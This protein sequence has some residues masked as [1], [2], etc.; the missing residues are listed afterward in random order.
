MKTILISFLAILVLGT[1]NAKPIRDVISIKEPALQAEAYVNDIPFN[2][3]LVAAE[4]LRVK[5]ALELDEETY[6]NDIP[7]DTRSIACKAL[8]CKMI[9]ENIEENINDIPFNTRKIYEECMMAQMIRDFECE[10]VERDIQFDTFRIANKQLM[11]DILER[12]REESDIKDIPYEIV[13]IIS[14]SRNNEPAYV[15]I[16]KKTK[17]R[18]NGRK[19]GT[20]AYEY[21]IYQPCKDGISA[22]EPFQST[23]TKELMVTPGSSL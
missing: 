2:T 14:T 16:K 18:S 8:M 22:P 11:A 3:A 7:F 23:L 21:T 4:S 10:K 20:D 13:C 9:S 12:Y 6:V 17:K 15:L 1:T 5:D 19:S